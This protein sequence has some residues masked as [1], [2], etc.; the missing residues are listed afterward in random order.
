MTN[1]SRELKITFCEFFDGVCIKL[2]PKVT[3]YGFWSICRKTIKRQDMV[4]SKAGFSG[5]EQGGGWFRRFPPS[6]KLA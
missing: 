3:A 4:G 5:A 2:G 6:K 1:F